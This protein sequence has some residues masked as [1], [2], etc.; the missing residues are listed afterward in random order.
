MVAG[1]N[2]EGQQGGGPLKKVKKGKADDF[3][4]D[5]QARRGKD[6]PKDLMILVGKM[7]LQSAQA[8]RDLSS[9]N[10]ETSL[11]KSDLESIKQGREAGQNYSEP[12]KNNKE[13]TLGPPFIHILLA[14]LPALA[15]DERVGAKNQQMISE[16][17]KFSETANLETMCDH[18]KLF[19]VSKT[20]RSDRVKIQF[21]FAEKIVVYK[22][23][24]E[25]KEAAAEMVVDPPD[26][27]ALVRSIAMAMKSVGMERKQGRAPAGEFERL[28]SKGLNMLEDEL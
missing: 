2:K 8:I 5:K 14:S 22:E 27:G 16:Y 24:Q 6:E 21:A 10:L 4:T 26:L 3:V 11:A 28:T 7:S 18:V 20:Y 9:V 13:H 25:G 12:V 23:E 15:K 1:K 19:R 17:I